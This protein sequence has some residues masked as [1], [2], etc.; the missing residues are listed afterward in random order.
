MRVYCRILFMIAFVLLLIMSACQPGTQNSALPEASLG[1]FPPGIFQNPTVNWTWEFRADGTYFAQ[2]IF[3]SER[4]TFTV[5]GD[6]IS[7]KGD[8]C[9]EITGTY[10]WTYEGKALTFNLLDDNCMDR[11]VV[12]DND[13]W[14]L[15]PQN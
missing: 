15:T 5:T 7:M 10:I 4:G 9:G 13:S 6:Q 1:D 3:K 8:H 12:I 14:F 2:G 11:R